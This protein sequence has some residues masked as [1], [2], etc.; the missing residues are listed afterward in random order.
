MQVYNDALA[1]STKIDE[2]LLCGRNQIA[3]TR[4]IG[5]VLRSTQLKDVCEHLFELLLRH[6]Q[7][8]TNMIQL[9]VAK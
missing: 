7:I 1:G 3:E 6:L 8:R 5:A 9:G 2:M 4:G